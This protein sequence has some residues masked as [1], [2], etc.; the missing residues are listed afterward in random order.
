MGH[1]DPRLRWHRLHDVSTAVK[2]SIDGY[3]ILAQKLEFEKPP[4]GG[5]IGQ[6]RS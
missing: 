2:V 5:F 6:K 4:A 3:L 1:D